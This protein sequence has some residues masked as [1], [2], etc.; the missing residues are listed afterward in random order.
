MFIASINRVTGMKSLKALKLFIGQF[1]SASK[2]IGF[3]DYY[4]ELNISLVVNGGSG[5]NQETF[6][7]QE[8]TSPDW[9]ETC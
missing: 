3:V 4:S 7:R 6:Q 2:P 8:I 1:A 5:S 9:P